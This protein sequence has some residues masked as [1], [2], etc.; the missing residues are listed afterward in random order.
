[1]HGLVAARLGYSEIALGF[2]R[3]AADIDLADTRVATDGGVHIAALGGNWMLTVL[4]FAGLS[5][6][7]SNSHFDFGGLAVG[8]SERRGS[9]TGGRQ[10]GIGGGFTNARVSSRSSQ[11]GKIR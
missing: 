9:E 1:M 4:G 6:R 2:L 8:I 5:L 10:G 7:D 11:D 3:K